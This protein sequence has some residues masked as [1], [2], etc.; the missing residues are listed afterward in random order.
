MKAP[1]AQAILT[2]FMG[3]LAAAKDSVLLVDY[4]GTLAP[5]Q[6]LRDRA[7]PYP[8]VEAILE[9]IVQ[10]GKTRVIVL[11][12]RPVRELQTLF[13]PLHNLE[14]WGSHGMEHLLRD[15]TYQQT[16]MDSGVAAV[17]G[18]AETWLTAAGL[19]PLAE[20]K[21]GGIAI[22]WRGLKDA[23]IKRVQTL[24]RQG[25]APFAEQ[26]GLRLLN[27]DAGLELRVAHPGKGDALAA[28]L[29]DLDSHTPIAFLGDDLTDEDGFRVLQDR[30]L[31][32]LVRPEYR[33]TRAKIWLQPPHELIAF[34]EQWLSNISSSVAEK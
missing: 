26:P 5:F 1:S 16:A 4:D 3:R 29:E 14:V 18:Q 24:A 7:Y 13:R 23:E 19:L 33:E 34:L 21:P 10:C 6:T 25:M 20:I 2:E 30:G 17:L 15:G 27:F 11:T 22:H 12:G 9:R 31:S 8:D 28:I 32:V